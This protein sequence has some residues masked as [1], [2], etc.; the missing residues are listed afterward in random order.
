M[1]DIIKL[2]K[3]KNIEFLSY[4]EKLPY[5]EKLKIEVLNFFKNTNKNEKI[6]L[7][8]PLFFLNEIL[9][10]NILNKVCFAS[11]F[12]Y[13]HINLNDT[14]Y[15]NDSLKKNEKSRIIFL[16]GLFLEEGIKLLTDLFKN[17]NIFWKVWNKRRMDFLKGINIDCKYDSNYILNWSEFEKLAVFRSSFGEIA[18]DIWFHLFPEKFNTKKRDKIIESQKYFTLGFQIL[19]DISD[20]KK[21]LND[22]QVNIAISETRSFRLKDAEENKKISSKEL[23]EF[24]YREGIAIQLYEKAFSYLNKSKEV[25]KDYEKELKYWFQLID[26][27]IKELQLNVANINYQF[28]KWQIQTNIS[29]KFKKSNTID[30]AIYNSLNYLLNTQNKDG[31]WNDFANNAGMSD[32]WSTG[33]I[34]SQIPKGLIDNPQ[35]INN[36]CNFLLSNNHNEIWGYNKNWIEDTDSTSCVLLALHQNNKDI[37]KEFEIWKKRQL[38]SGGFSTYTKNTNLYS[39]L[40][41][42]V[43]NFQ[44]WIKE[45]ICVSAL[46]YHFLCSY[47]TKNKVTE[48]IENFLFEEIESELYWNSYWWTSPVYSTSLILETLITYKRKNFQTIEKIASKLIKFLNYDDYLVKD[49]TGSSNLFFTAMIVSSICSSKKIYLLNKKVIDNSIISMLKNQFE[50]GSFPSSNSLQIPTPS[51]INPEEI[52]KWSFNHRDTNIISSD[53]MRSFTTVNCLKAIEKYKKIND[54]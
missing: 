48:K 16:S 38:P 5:P 23:I 3:N 11:Y 54:G 28:K 20:F 53:F 9:N 46:A 33:Y 6:Y 27:K 14:L 40:S 41:F 36:A 51:T 22:N 44:G 1:N 24:F 34:L 15:D 12:I 42:S 8:Y 26:I 35:I 19:D 10:S 30:S 45:H 52:K 29:N 7:T 43:K 32:V 49:S 17:S 4:C 39:S 18:V 37:S 31:S 13:T 50:D 47:D 2:Q 21:D 25:V